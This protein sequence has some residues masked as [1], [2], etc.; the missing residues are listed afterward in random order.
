MKILI[1]SD[2][3]ANMFALEAV[4]QAE[5]DSDMVL[6]AG[7]LVDWGF[8]PREV[9]DWC[10]FHAV[11]AVAGNHDRSLC[12]IYRAAQNG[13]AIPAGTFAA[14]NLSQLRP[15]D[16]AYLEALPETRAVQAGAFAFW[17]KHYYND[18]EEDRTALLE[19]WIHFEAKTA[20]DSFWPSHLQADTRVFLTGH[21]HQCW[22]YQVYQGAFFL[23]PGSVSYRVCSDSRSKGADYAVVQDGEIRLRHVDYDRRVF[24][25]LLEQANLQNEVRR[26]AAC[27]L[28]T[29]C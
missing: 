22:L 27:H 29:D 15:Q 9:L 18:A 10:R 7:D 12:A 4:W 24:I 20:F 16:I 1:L 28:V 26:S 6:C 17:I 23:N 13:E 8:Q 19:R 3:H 25:P 11:A 5:C 21:S 14:Q 2:I